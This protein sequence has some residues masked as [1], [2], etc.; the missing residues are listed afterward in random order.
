MVTQR[1]KC[2]IHL[3]FEIY[4]LITKPTL[5]DN[6][7]GWSHT[8][9]RWVTR[10]PKDGHQPTQGQVTT[11]MNGQP[12][13]LGGSRTHPRMVTHQKKVYH[14]LGLLHLHITHLVTYNSLDDN[15][16]TLGWPLSRWSSTT[17][18]EFVNY[19]LLTKL[20]PG[21]NCRGWSPTI[22]RRVTHKP[23]NSHPPT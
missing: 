8:I 23:K 13:S 16:P 10:Q 21:I 17:D 11:A 2:T 20:T 9:P 14:R 15:P 6:Y 1:R 22:R 12:P 18:L 7:H 4:T 5:G 3:E 19:T